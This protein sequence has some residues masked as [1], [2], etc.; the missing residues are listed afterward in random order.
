D[1]V[2]AK[3]VSAADV[4]RHVVNKQAFGRLSLGQLLAVLEKSRVGLANANFIGQDQ[5]IEMGQRIGE[6]LLEAPG[7]QFIGVA[8]QEESIAG[9]QPRNQLA[10]F[11]IRP[12]H[13]GESQ[14]QRFIAA[15]KLKLVPYFLQ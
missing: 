13:V 12:K 7:M 10:N 6:L 5:S 14:L 11:P 4:S 2:P 15:T 1:C 3:G 9:F 8:A